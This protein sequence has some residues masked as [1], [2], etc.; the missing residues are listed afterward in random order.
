[1]ELTLIASYLSG[2]FAH[3]LTDMIPISYFYV[4]LELLE[5]VCVFIM[6]TLEGILEVT[7]GHHVSCS[8]HRRLSEKGL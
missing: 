4:P 1:M 7:F 6:P 3:S 2:Q 8:T 5:L